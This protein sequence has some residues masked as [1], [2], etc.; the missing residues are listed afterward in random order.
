MCIMMFYDL[1][2]LSVSLSLRA[3]SPGGAGGGAG[4]IA[5]VIT[6]GTCFLM[7]VKRNVNVT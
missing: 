5:R 2:D 1:I 3:S 7:L 6:L 4:K